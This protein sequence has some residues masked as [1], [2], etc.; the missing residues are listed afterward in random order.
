[1]VRLDERR[2]L[3]ERIGHVCV[4][5]LGVVVMTLVPKVISIMEESV[6]RFLHLDGDLGMLV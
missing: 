4:S 1:M 5:R 6:W 2:V 3:K